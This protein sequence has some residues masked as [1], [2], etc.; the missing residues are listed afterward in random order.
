MNDRTRQEPR[1]FERP[2]R[3]RENF[4][5]GKRTGGPRPR[6]DAYNPRWQS[7]PASQRDYRGYESSYERPTFR[8]TRGYGQPEG[9]QFEGDYEHFA[10]DEEVEQ[11]K[12]GYEPHVTRL[13]DGRVLKG[14]RPAQRTAARFWT[15]VEEDAQALLPHTPTPQEQEELTPLPAVQETPAT[16]PARPRKQPDDQARRVKTVK[17]TRAREQKPREE[18]AEKKKA[19]TQKTIIY[20]SQ[21]GYRWPATGGE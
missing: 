8:Q 13:P 1:D 6:R 15:D 12:Q 11:P 19:R 18:K 14:S 9:A 7:R 4:A 21:R 2:D 16:R 10:T 3:E 20:P 17:T 5:R